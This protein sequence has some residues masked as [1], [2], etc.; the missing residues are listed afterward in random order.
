MS[1]CSCV[2]NSEPVNVWEAEFPGVVITNQY[3]EWMI[4]EPEAA[5]RRADDECESG[6]GSGSGDN[7]RGD[8]NNNNNRNNVNNNNNSSNLNLNLDALRGGSNKRAQDSNENENNENENKQPNDNDNEDNSDD[9]NASRQEP[10]PVPSYLSRN[11]PSLNDL[12]AHN[13]PTHLRHL[14]NTQTQR[15][16][17]RLRGDASSWNNV[18]LLL[19]VAIMALVLR[20]FLVTLS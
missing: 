2:Y 4:E 17:V 16:R 14:N 11:N 13:I 19:V 10:L 8:N 7:R 9:V 15:R 1:F 18:V 5:P 3:A 12:I 20:K 6:S